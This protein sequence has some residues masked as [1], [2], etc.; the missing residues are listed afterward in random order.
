MI[1]PGGIL[2]TGVAKP[3]EKTSAAATGATTS[4]AESKPAAEPRKRRSRWGATPEPS[5]NATD[6]A[7]ATNKVE[8]AQLGTTEEAPP[9]RKKSRWGVQPEA[10][11]EAQPEV[12]KSR[13]GAEKDGPKKS[14]WGAKDTDP[15]MEHTLQLA[16][17]VKKHNMAEELMNQIPEE[18]R[19]PSPAPVYGDKGECVNNRIV[20]YQAKV[21]KEREQLMRDYYNR[22]PHMCPPHLRPKI[23]RRIFIPYRE[24][25]NYNFF[26]LIV[27]PR[28]STQ[29]R[30]ERETG[31]KVFIRGKGSV[32]DGQRAVDEDGMDEDMHVFIQGETEEQVE[33]AAKEVS[34]ML[35]PDSKDHQEHKAKQ[36]QELS[37]LNGTGRPDDKCFGCGQTGHQQAECPDRF[38]RPKVHL[39]CGIC[40]D[41]SHPTQDCHMKAHGGPLPGG[42]A[43]SLESEYDNF[44]NDIGAG[45]PGSSTRQQPPPWLQGATSGDGACRA[46][47]EGDPPGPPP[48]PPPAGYTPWGV[49]QAQPP[50][51]GTA[52]A[53]PW[54][55]PGAAPPS[56]PSSAPQLPQGAPPGG[57]GMARRPWEAPPPGPP[58]GAPPGKFGEP[59]KAA[60]K[61]GS[62]G[63]FEAL[64]YR[65]QA[66]PDYM[67]PEEAAAE[68]YDF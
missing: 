44:M 47:V 39:K 64:D 37:V 15:H 14:R 19:S 31:C 16:R 34:M 66:I 10:P 55:A 61:K 50:P 68:G 58:P 4:T 21:A 41:G 2:F 28:G 11:P 56:A 8:A 33:H 48:G 23:T 36:L 53:P 59:A 5:G 25:P 67:P 24:Y 40:G 27:G 35:N 52:Q 20:R 45:G 22:F 43:K 49:A 3:A 63:V 32:K 57:F 60:P 9:A 17:L 7:A 1:L 6:P 46:F 51:W 30:L 65:V 38:Q 26:G 62:G 42:G 29:K 54:G 18:E 12:K 13:W